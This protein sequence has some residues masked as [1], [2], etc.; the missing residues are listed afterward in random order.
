[1]A[2]HSTVQVTHMGQT[3]CSVIGV[4]MAALQGGATASRLTALSEGLLQNRGRTGY[5]CSAPTGTR[6]TAPPPTAEY[7]H[8][9]IT[10]LIFT[11]NT[12]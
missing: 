9:G 2:N 6:Y 5:T 4:A 3:W 11:I 12:K 7:I 1:M 8:S 10:T